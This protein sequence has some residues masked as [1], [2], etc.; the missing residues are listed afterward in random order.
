VEGSSVDLPVLWLVFV[1]LLLLLILVLCHGYMLRNRAR[2]E[3]LR[4]QLPTI[5]LN[6][7]LHAPDAATFMII[8]GSGD[9]EEYVRVS[10]GPDARTLYVHERLGKPSKNI[11]S[12]S[13]KV[14][15]HG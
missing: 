1:I 2:A 11:P 12:K 3:A 6:A 13:P 8:I 14:E 4:R 15:D 9:D 10:R 5:T 7:P